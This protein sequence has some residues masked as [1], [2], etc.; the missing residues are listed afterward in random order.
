[1]PLLTIALGTLLVHAQGCGGGGNAPPG[2]PPSATPAAP[3]AAAHSA[4][5]SSSASAAVVVFTES[6]F[7]ESDSSRDPFHSWVRQFA[8]SQAPVQMPT[9]S[10]L[11]EKYS[12]DELRLAAIIN[13][14]EGYTA[15]FIDPTGRGWS[16][17]RGD[18]ICRGEIVKLGDKYQSS[19]PLFWKV[20]RVKETEVVLMRE[21]S[22][23]P[24]VPPTYRE[25]QLHPE[26][27]KT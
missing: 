25:I 15:M 4:S 9:Y 7:S 22:L 27:E 23:H 16:I 14:G 6:D 1:M 21:D 10:V 12:V 19:Y 13:A 18:H 5:A 3:A 26:A 8:P 20:D 17:K 11:L 2:P 24:E